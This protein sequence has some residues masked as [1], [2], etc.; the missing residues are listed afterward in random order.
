M[1]AQILPTFYLPMVAAPFLFHYYFSKNE[2]GQ[3]GRMTYEEIKQNKEILAF[4]KK[5]NDNLGAM[6]YTDHSEAQPMPFQPH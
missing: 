2:S 5:G 4:I 6:G 3:V 1:Q